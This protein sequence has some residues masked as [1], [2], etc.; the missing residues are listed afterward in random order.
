MQ[1]ASGS[2][3]DG[4]RRSE[5]DGAGVF[6]SRRV[7][8]RGRIGEYLG[9]RVAHAAADRRSAGEAGNGEH[10]IPFVVGARAV[11]D[12]GV[13]GSAARGISHRCDPNCETVAGSRRIFIEAVGDTEIGAEFD[14]D[15][16]LG[17]DGDDPPNIEAVF[18]CRRRATAC[19][20]TMLPPERLPARRP[21]RPRGGRA[22]LRCA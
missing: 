22:A 21:A 1:S 5:I 3:P 7:A 14:D 10:T 15:Y 9:E 11:I 8:K 16:R 19:R 18:G 20:G 4:V 6:T 17:R 13:A 2:L 12:A